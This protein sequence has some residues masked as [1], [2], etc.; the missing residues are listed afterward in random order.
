MYDVKSVKEELKLYDDADLIMSLY[1]E[2]LV[3][4]S[5]K[6]DEERFPNCK[7]GDVIDREASV[8]WNEEEVERRIV[9]RDEEVK[10]LNKLKSEISEL[11]RE[12]MI[13][14]LAKEYKISKDEMKVIY[15]KAYEEGHSCGMRE[16]LNYCR[17]FADFY[18]DLRNVA[19]K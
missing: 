19:K 15:S 4:F 3:D 14:H 17:D 9:A 13:K 1:E 18:E 10:R 2:F 6:P 5:C 8:R 12:A 16:V 7:R 11:Y